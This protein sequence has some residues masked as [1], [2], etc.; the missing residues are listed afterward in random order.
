MILQLPKDCP[1]ATRASLAT[2]AQTGN[3]WELMSPEGSPWPETDRCRCLEL[4]PRAP[5]QGQDEATPCGDPSVLTLPLPD[6]P[7][8][9]T[10]RHTLNASL[11]ISPPLGVC[12]WGNG[13]MAQSTHLTPH[14]LSFPTGQVGIIRQSPK[15]RN[16]I[17]LWTE[18]CPPTNSYVEVP[19]LK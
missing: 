3:A 17:L 14:C 2:P 13:P 4:T 12:F 11:H 8:S 7:A 1:G 18:L 9:P 5:L 16:R 15:K 6:P 19:T 10:R